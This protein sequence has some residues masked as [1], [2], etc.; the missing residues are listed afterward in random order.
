[1]AP[2]AI[3]GG[4]MMNETDPDWIHFEIG[5]AADH[6]ADIRELYLRGWSRNQIAETL[7]IP[8]K[9]VVRRV[10]KMRKYGVIPRGAPY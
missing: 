9:R 2:L 4:D 10:I 7:G 1:M 6:D 8:Y 5:P 3:E